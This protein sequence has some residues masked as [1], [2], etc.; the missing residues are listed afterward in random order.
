MTGVRSS[1]QPLLCSVH[2]VDEVVLTGLLAGSSLAKTHAYQKVGV[3][4]H[5]ESKTD[6]LKD[7]VHF[8]GY[9]GLEHTQTPPLG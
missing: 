8:K 9:S 3:K 4:L 2:D 7:Q 1:E 5:K 6:L